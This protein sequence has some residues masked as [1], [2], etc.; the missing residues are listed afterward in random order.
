VKSATEDLTELLSPLADD[1]KSARGILTER[2]F[3]AEDFS[4]RLLIARNAAAQD[5]SELPGWLE[6]I[7]EIPDKD[8][9]SLAAEMAEHLITHGGKMFRSALVL[10]VIRACGGGAQDAAKLAAA[11]EMIHMATLLHDDVI[12]RSDTRRGAASMPARFDNSPTVLMGDHLFA[13]AFELLSECG[14]VEIVASAARA[15]SKMCLGEVEQLEWI[16]RA[17]IPEEVYF[18]LI[19]RKTAALM[20]SCCETAAFLC[21]NDSHVEE[22]NKF[23]CLL[24]LIFQMVDD[25]LD[26]TADEQRLGKAV[27]SD[28][29]AGKYTLPLILYRDRLGSREAFAEFLAGCASQE[30]IRAALEGE[31]VF[32]DVRSRIEDLVE[33]CQGYLNRLADSQID[34]AGCHLLSGM[35]DFVALRDY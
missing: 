35:V 29:E 31:C 2:I 13:R 14:R 7:T 33:N 10:A 30:D 12:D 24:G 27:G 8:D 16:G 4:E 9:G 25:L 28:A 23:G 19:E 1:L 3:Q 21:E 17:D 15:T 26:F 32:K 34:P 18:R 6:R 5:A 22:W 20:A 11:M